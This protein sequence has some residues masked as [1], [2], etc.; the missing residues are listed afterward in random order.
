MDYPAVYTGH[1]SETIQISQNV[2]FRMGNL[3]VRDQCNAGIVV[4]TQGILLID[5]PAQDPEEEILEEAEGFFGKKVTHI[6]LTHAHPDHR[7]GLAMLRRRAVTLVSTAAGKSGVERSSPEFRAESWQVVGTGDRWMFEDTAF[8]FWCPAALPAHSPWDLC[9]VLPEERLIFTGD[10]LVPPFY[11]YTH[12]S[13]WKNWHAAVQDFRQT[14]C[15][16]L[17]L[18][19]H[20]DPQAQEALLPVVEGYLSRLGKLSEDYAPG[21]LEALWGGPASDFPEDM[22]RLVQLTGQETVR[23][24]LRE[25]QEMSALA[26]PRR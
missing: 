7:N 2:F 26:V 11:L 8:R 1:L 18:M 17:L 10:F 19:G 23:R 14:F 15:G 9:A 22:K 24:Q 12:G 21:R 5:L 6:L 4:G 13:N 25:I 20:G 16:A 3:P